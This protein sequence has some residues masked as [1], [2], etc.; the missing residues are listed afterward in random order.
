[1][2]LF[3]DWDDGLGRVED[4]ADIEIENLGKFVGGS[5]INFLV[6]GDTGIVD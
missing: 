4:S 6:G 5:V 3:H 1:M 2:L